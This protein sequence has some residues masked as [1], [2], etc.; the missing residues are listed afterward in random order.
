MYKVVS[1][2]NPT[3]TIRDA[4]T[5]L[6]QPGSL[7]ELRCPKTKK[8]GTIS[9]YFTDLN[10]L[11]DTAALLS[12]IVPAVYVTLN[13]VRP[14]LL[15]RAANR[16]EKRAAFTT[17]DRD[18]VRRCRL[19][20]DFDPV[21]PAGISSTDSE[22]EIALDR[23][24]AC[25]DW[26]A[27]QGFPAPI[28][29]DSGNGGHLVYGIDLP[30]DEE[31]RL[32]IE[33]VL[34]V[35]A[36]R[37]GDDTVKVD[38][39]VFNAARISKLY[40]TMACKGDHLRE[41]P[42]RLARI[43]EA[44]AALTS[45]PRELLE[46]VAA[47]QTVTLNA[48]ELRAE[49]QRLKGAPTREGV[50]WMEA[51]LNRHKVGVRQ[52]KDDN[53]EWRCRWILEQCPFC[54]SVDTAAAIV[55][56]HDG[57]FGFRCQ[58]NR[59]SD[60]RKTWHDFRD[61]Y[62]PDRADKR[63]KSAALRLVD[64]ARR[65]CQLFTTPDGVAYAMIPAGRKQTVKV[66]SGPFRRW[67]AG[68]AQQAGF[69][70]GGKALA[71]AALALD[72][73]AFEAHE[74]RPVHLRFA[75]VDDVIYLDLANDQGEIVVVTRD[76]WK[77]TTECPVAFIRPANMAALPRPERGGDLD[78]L[79]QFI[80]VTDAD[81]PL[82]R[83]FLL[84]CLKGVGPYTVLL[85]NG[86]QGSAKSTGSKYLRSLLDPVHKAP[87][88][89]L[90]R[91]EYELA[92]AAQQNAILVFD[93]VSSLPQWLS[94][95]IAS[96]ATGSGFAVRTLYSQD[97]EMVYG[98]ARPVAFNGIPD[99]AESSDL[100][101]RAIKVTLPPIPDAQRKS[102]D[103]LE[104]LFEAARPKLLGALLDA[105]SAGLKN[106]A[107]MNLGAL[108]RMARSARWIAACEEGL[109][110][111]QGVFLTAYERTREE[112]TTLALDHSTVATAL[113]TWMDTWVDTVWEGSAS[114][115]LGVL[116]DQVHGV[117]LC[118]NAFPKAP[119]KLSGEL[120][121]IGPALR[122]VG[123]TVDLSRSRLGSCIKIQ[124]AVAKTDSTVTTAPRPV[125][126]PTLPAV[127]EGRIPYDLPYELTENANGSASLSFRPLTNHEMARLDMN[128]RTQIARR[129]GKMVWGIR[130][131]RRL[132]G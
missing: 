27:E 37:F 79:R 102:E 2:E 9:G 12:G 126:T 48:K 104:P 46:K 91:D 92:I 64:A 87:A 15:A 78:D 119:N 111:Q 24:R 99:F 98:T 59:C 61:H 117:V 21:R 81:F 69:L 32:L 100:L 53:G 97:E 8:D 63:P 7:Y 41:R 84:D 71:D 42:H 120:R 25:R 107:A 83:G 44:P 38:T 125:S 86:E 121:R 106:Y 6:C 16:I 1:F 18:I 74:V 28:L 123:I 131:G 103:E 52:V 129:D 39:T 57:T 50:D 105:A 77:I 29:A 19:L 96:L 75:R 72:A 30:N 49:G 115:L 54:Q 40:G 93:N 45:V 130:P 65:Q 31:A 88:R 122:R 66:Q 35:A 47:M 116:T 109:A 10:K 101:D 60:P 55:L 11:A 34:K 36:E 58:H 43:L 13:P 62:E 4:L 17:A 67:L 114:E 3:P 23:T 68:L 127:T 94:D 20:L 51:F 112:M 14:D 132:A 89:R 113:L 22:H 110:G 70:A 128:T 85:I 33:S 80:N 56:S 90:Q 95:A 73:A 124:R 118:S 82:L 26:F 76:G 108:P 5:L